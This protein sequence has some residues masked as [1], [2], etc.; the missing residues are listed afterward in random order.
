LHALALLTLAAAG[1]AAAQVPPALP[2]APARDHSIHN[3]HNFPLNA[4]MTENGMELR[5]VARTP[6]DPSVWRSN[7]G[8]SVWRTNVPQGVVLSVSQS[9]VF[10]ERDVVAAW[11]RCADTLAR[12]AAYLADFHHGL[13]RSEPPRSDRPFDIAIVLTEPMADPGDRRSIA[14]ECVVEPERPEAVLTISYRASPTER[15]RALERVWVEA[16]AEVVQRTR[17]RYRLGSGE[18]G[19][20]AMFRAYDCLFVFE[21]SDADPQRNRGYF[22]FDLAQAG[23]VSASAADEVSIVA[24][25]PR[26]LSL[27]IDARSLAEA[28]RTR[29]TGLLQILGRR[30]EAARAP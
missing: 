3:A 30:C 9:T 8:L 13:V 18:T 12:Q 22:H 24:H 5:G 29:L 21:A 17:P 25:V 27:T 2:A 1:N 19:T 23:R 16:V 7:D 20:L 10:R 6:A 28:D 4:G 11:R 15:R 26:P 14:L